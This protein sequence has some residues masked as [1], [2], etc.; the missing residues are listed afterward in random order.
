MHEQN[1][2]LSLIT[3]ALAIVERARARTLIETLEESH[4]AV[5]SGADKDL[6]EQERSLRE[7]IEA[8]KEIQVAALSRSGR[9][10]QAIQ[11]ARTGRPVR[12][13]HGDPGDDSVKSPL[14]S[15]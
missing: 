2:I 3:D 4:L 7:L 5:R 11:R 8:K 9:D 14:R 6:Q 15:A 10:D 13:P 12:S 1:P